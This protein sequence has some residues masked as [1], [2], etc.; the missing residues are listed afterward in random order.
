MLLA[1]IYDRN[2]STARI[3]QILHRCAKRNV[4]TIMLDD[5]LMF[6]TLKDIVYLFGSSNFQAGVLLSIM[7]AVRQVTSVFDFVL[8][9]S[10][11]FLVILFFKVILFK[12]SEFPFV[13][14]NIAAPTTAS[15]TMITERTT[16][17]VKLC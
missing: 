8:F 15:S 9:C 4:T 16:S 7:S 17:N 11:L 12:V 3:I 5:I 6:E 14:I 2:T 10:F 1:A 13:Q